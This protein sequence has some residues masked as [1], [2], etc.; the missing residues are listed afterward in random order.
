MDRGAW[1][2]IIHGIT[3]LDKTKQLIKLAVFNLVLDNFK[4]Y[5]FIIR[6]DHYNFPVKSQSLLAFLC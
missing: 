2:A 5:D 1:E 6:A 4:L 3:E